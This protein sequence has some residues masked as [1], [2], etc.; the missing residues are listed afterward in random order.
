MDIFRTISNCST[1]SIQG[2]SS[3]SN[4]S[5]ESKKLSINLPLIIVISLI[6]IHLKKRRNYT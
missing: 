2:S 3:I 4:S 1:E 5:T 6:S